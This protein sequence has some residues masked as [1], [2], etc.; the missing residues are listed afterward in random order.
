MQKR[1]RFQ[2]KQEIKRQKC[3]AEGV[4]FLPSTLEEEEPKFQFV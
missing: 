3:Y 1:V 2:Q 4:E